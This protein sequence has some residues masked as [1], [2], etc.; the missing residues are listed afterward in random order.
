MFEEI[1][2]TLIIASSGQRQFKYMFGE[3]NAVK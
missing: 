2:T 3:C 1:R